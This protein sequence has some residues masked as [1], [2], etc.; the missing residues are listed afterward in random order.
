MDVPVCSNASLPVRRLEAPYFTV[1]NRLARLSWSVV[2]FCLFLPTPRPFHLWRSMLLRS[3]GARLGTNCHIYSTVKIWAP[4]NLECGNRVG[5]AEDAEIYNPS[6]VRLGDDSVIS[7]GA[8]LCGASHDPDSP[9]F[10]L[11]TAPIVVEKRAWV[12]ARALVLMGITLGEGCVVTR[13][14]PPGAICAGNPCRVV[15]RSEERSKQ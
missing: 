9:T 13:D 8:Y 10:T 5:V 3:F 1:R 4:W 11:L 6:L 7:Q 14:I 15:K 2:Y 12:A